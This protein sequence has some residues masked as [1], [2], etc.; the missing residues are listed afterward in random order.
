M[1]TINHIE[2]RDENLKN[3]R[4]KYQPKHTEKLEDIPLF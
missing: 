3:E 1:R 2:N 4:Y